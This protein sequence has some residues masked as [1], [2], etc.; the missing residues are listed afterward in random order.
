MADKTEQ[1]HP[2]GLDT[3]TPSLCKWCVL[4]TCPKNQNK[5]KIRGR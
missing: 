1:T 2:C 5:S 4:F 3:P